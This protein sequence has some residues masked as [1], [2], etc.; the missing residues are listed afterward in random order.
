MRD[1]KRVSTIYEVWK[2]I[3]LAHDDLT[4]FGSYSAP[5]GDY[6]G[7]PSRGK[8]FTSYGFRQGDYPIMEAETT[9]DIS[10]EEPYKRVNEE[11]KYWL[12]LPMKE[13]D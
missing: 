12:C 11:H 3:K 5:D 8:M 4:V 13:E 7:D 9:W 1:Y 6:Y 10:C 2:A